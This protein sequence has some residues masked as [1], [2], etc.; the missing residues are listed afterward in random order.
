MSTAPAEG[1]GGVSNPLSQL[2]RKGLKIAPDTSVIKDMGAETAEV[3]EEATPHTPVLGRHLPPDLEAAVLVEPEAP[4]PTV[5]APAV[6]TPT[7]EPAK[8]A[9]AKEAV[10]STRQRA[11]E[12]ATPGKQKISYLLPVDVVERLRNACPRVGSRATGPFSGS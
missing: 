2:R 11:S 7:P 8:P 10:G 4:I 5:A 12:S 9:D 6:L 1:R 3:Q